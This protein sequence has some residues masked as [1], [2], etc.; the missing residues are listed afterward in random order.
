MSSELVPQ[1]AYQCVTV[2]VIKRFLEALSLGCSITGA[3]SIAGIS[4]QEAYRW[5]AEDVTDVTIPAYEI[6]PGALNNRELVERARERAIGKHELIVLHE[7]LNRKNAAMALQFL[8]LH[9]PDDWRE[10][11]Q[12]TQSLSVNMD[13]DWEKLTPEQLRRI[14][15][16]EDVAGVLADSATG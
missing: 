15:Q 4:R 16:G 8:R 14:A 11:P 7:A 3:A 5:I 12:S 13:L 6:E 2:E 9:A 10:K 1:R